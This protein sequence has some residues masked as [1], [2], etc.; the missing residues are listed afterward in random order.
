MN[1][2]A[3][4]ILGVLFTFSL[5]A[6]ELNPETQ[7]KFLKILLSSSGQFGFHC[8]DPGLRKQLEANGIAVSDGFK[9]AWAASEAEVKTL[10]A[11]GK[12]VIVPKTAWLKTGGALALVAEDGKPVIYINPAHVKASGMTLPDTIVKMAKTAK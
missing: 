3:L 1:R 12:L 4:A 9:M 8:D 10:K 11:Q 6:Q 2:F 7:A 5:G